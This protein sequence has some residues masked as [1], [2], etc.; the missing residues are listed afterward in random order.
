MQA[1]LWDRI[2]IADTVGVEVISL[3]DAPR[4]YD[5]FDQGAP[6]KFVLDPHALLKAA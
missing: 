2:Q 1:I 5:A 3:D 6:R 4:G